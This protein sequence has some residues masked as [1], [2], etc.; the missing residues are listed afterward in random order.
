MLTSQDI[1][2]LVE[3]FKTRSE[4]DED[5]RKLE[6]KMATKDDFRQAM[7]VL[8]KVLKEVLAMRQEQDFH[9]QEHRDIRDE[10]NAIKKRSLSPKLHNI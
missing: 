2:L 10:I 8:D 3:S 1:K 9:T 4:A 6:E 5:L 7:I